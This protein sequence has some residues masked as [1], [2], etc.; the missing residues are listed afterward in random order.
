MKTVQDLSKGCF[1]N[2]DKPVG[3]TSHDIDLILRKVFKVK[4]TSHFGTLD[5][6]VTGILPI[7]LG[8]GVKLFQYMRSG[9]EYVGVM[10]LHEDIDKKKVEEVIKRHFTGKIKQTPPV[11]SRVKRVEREREI[12][13]FK[14]LEQEGK[15][16]LFH[17]DCEAG[18]Y[19]RKLLHDLGEKL[20]I[21]AHMAELRRVRAGMFNESNIVRIDEI[22]RAVEAN[23][24]KTLLKHLIPKEILLK[25]MKSID[26]NEEGMKRVGQ[27]GPLFQSNLVKKAKV[28]KGDKVGVLFNNELIAIHTIVDVERFMAKPDSV[29]I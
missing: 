3:K 19:I 11:K 6:M 16:F 17:V 2:I 26:V 12:Y 21:G 28:E 8:K 25:E 22:V 18:T 4:K 29:L 10:R 15:N 20:G 23:D 27:G 1:I 9:K 14:I 24:E 5:P 7:A 13:S